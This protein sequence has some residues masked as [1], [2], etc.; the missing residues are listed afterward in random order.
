MVRLGASN[1]TYALTVIEPYD[2][3]FESRE[4]TLPRINA[5]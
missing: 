1:P 5:D 2:L 3:A 4:K